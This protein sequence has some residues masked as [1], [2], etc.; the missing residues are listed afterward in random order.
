LND[1]D[2]V[3]SSDVCTNKT[4]RLGK[5]SDCTIAG[6]FFRIRIV[7]T[8]ARKENTVPRL[9]IRR[10]VA[11]FE[12]WKPGYDSHLSARQKAGLVEEHVLRN[13]DD[14][15]EVFLLFKADDF[16]KA[17][18]FAASDDLREKMQEAGVTD[19]PDI[20]FLT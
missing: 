2:A 13:A 4:V 3:S 14:P 10:K 6:R 19:K 12:Q 17:T 7:P 20:Y 1:D 18:E 9:L 11:H 8:S 5:V 16:Q 15:S